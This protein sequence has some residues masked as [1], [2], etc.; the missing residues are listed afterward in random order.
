MSPPRPLPSALWT[1]SLL[2]AVLFALSK[3][4]T[5]RAACESASSLHSC[6]NAN[7]LWSHAGA[8]PFIVIGGSDIPK[9]GTVALASIATYVSKPIVLRVPSSTSDLGQANLVNDAFYLD[10]SLAVGLLG[11]LELSASL[12][13]AIYQTGSGIGPYSSSRSDAL[14]A[15][16]WGDPRIGAAYR[17][18]SR[19]KDA[20]SG[21][22]L[23]TRLNLSLPFGDKRA[24]TSE[25]GPVVM[26]TLA[27]DYRLGGWFFGAETGV[28]VRD[29]Y[30]FA[31]AKVG[32]QG[33]FALG[34]GRAIIEDAFA[35]AVEAIAMPIF[36][37]QPSGDMSI[38][39]EWMAEA[40]TKP[41]SNTE[42]SLALGA[43]SALPLSDS[44]MT[45]ARWRAVLM[46]RY[47]LPL[48]L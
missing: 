45:A 12:P 7:Q 27:G 8:G 4:S 16:A 10:L 23:T 43:G 5:A 11:S 13:M 29:P 37:S 32:T 14:A 41:F 36:V 25:A 48:G 15:S 2:V 30:R 26:M 40:R 42:W 19:E 22:A 33:V 46:A 3:A 24:F 6:V 39:A 18:L 28:R 31:S 35:L 21:F 47:G 44:A 34:A 1:R 17:L 20:E 38:P 9:A